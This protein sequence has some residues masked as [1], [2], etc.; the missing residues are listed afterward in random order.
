MS[1]ATGSKNSSK[2]QLDT[3][4]LRRRALQEA[5]A[6]ASAHSLAFTLIHIALAT[7][8]AGRCSDADGRAWVANHRVW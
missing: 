2:A 8:Y 3:A 1:I 6:A 5:D 7:A 4:Y